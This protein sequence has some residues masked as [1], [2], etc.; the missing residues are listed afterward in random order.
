M[1][2]PAA[3]H[4]ALAPGTYRASGFWTPVTLVV[5]DAGWTSFG[6]DDIWVQLEHFG[7]DRL[8]PDL[9]VSVLAQSPGVGIAEVAATIMGYEQGEVLESSEPSSVAGFEALVFDVFVPAFPAGYCDDVAQRRRDEVRDVGEFAMSHSAFPPNASGIVLLYDLSGTS[10]YAFGV[11]NCRTARIWVVDVRGSTITI[12]AATD[13]TEDAADLMATAEGLLS[14][15][16]LA[17]GP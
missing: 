2:L 1:E 6:A 16:E 11:R 5:D 15:L 12:V 9:S 10:G 7:S 4:L 13:L 8:F 14:G 3:G 17:D